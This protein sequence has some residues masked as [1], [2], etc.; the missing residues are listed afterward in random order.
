MVFDS[1]RLYS[2][3]SRFRRFARGKRATS[4]VRFT[5]WFV[6]KD[7]RVSMRPEH[8]YRRFQLEML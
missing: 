6:G 3:T 4:G 5:D 7:E 1:R 8:N 2:S